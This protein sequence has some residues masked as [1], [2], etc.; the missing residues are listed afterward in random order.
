MVTD[1]YRNDYRDVSSKKLQEFMDQY[2]FDPMIFKDGYTTPALAT[3]EDRYKISINIYDIGKDGPEQ[4][5]P[6]YCSI[7][8]GDSDDQIPKICM[9]ILRNDQGDV[10][11]VLI[12]KLQAIFTSAYDK[13]HGHEKM[14]QDCGVVCSTTEQLLRHYQQDQRED[15]REQQILILPSSPKKAWIRF[16]LENKYDFQ[17]T[18][19]YFF[20]C[21]ADFECSNI[22]VEDPGTKKTKIIMKQVPNSFMIFCPDLMFLDDKRPLS[23][24]SYLK[25]FHSDDPYQVVQ[26]FVHALDTIRTTS[27]FRFQSHPRVSKLTNEEQKKFQLAKECEKCKMTFNPKTRPKVRHHCH[28]TCKYIG[29]W[30]RKCNLLERRTHFKLVVYFHNLRG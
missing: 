5:K 12:K 3:F 18:Q 29:A 7:Y 21:Y 26:E 17:K 22:P 28:I 19:R 16:E 11:F 30:C 13:N 25:K 14:C 20:D 1:K 15:S 24:D 10:H 4:T 27:I 2:N 9:G 23:I 6:Y 8:N